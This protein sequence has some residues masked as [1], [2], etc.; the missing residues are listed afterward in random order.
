MKEKAKNLIIRLLKNQLVKGSTTLFLGG[1]IGNLANYLYHLLMG[2]MLG[3][4]D[5]GALESVISLLYIFGIPLA[6]VNL[7]VVRTVSGLRGRGQEKKAAS[8]YYSLRRKIFS[9]AVGG[10]ILLFAAAPFIKNFLHLSSAW[11]V[12]VM[13]SHSFLG[14]FTGLNMAFLGAF[15]KFLSVSLI[16]VFQALAKLASGVLLVSLG[17]SVLGGSMAFLIGAILG[18][19]ISNF[20]IRKLL[21]EG[22]YSESQVRLKKIIKDAAAPFILTISFTSLYTTDI[23]LA[24]HFLP[25]DQAGFYAALSVLGKIIFFAAGPVAAT[26][27]PLV[28]SRHAAGADYKKLFLLS[29]GLVFLIC[30]SV[31]LVYWAFPGLMVRMLFGPKYQASAQHL[32]IFGLFLSFYSLANLICQF[33]LSISRN[34]VVLFP[35]VAALFQVILILLFHQNLFEV[36]FVSMIVSGLLFFILM[37]YSLVTQNTSG[38]SADFTLEVKGT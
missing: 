12:L 8:F 18:L 11:P 6:A 29:L 26:M 22:N 15:L 20:I 36:A 13:I 37:V 27:F 24:R 2:R 1:I 30:L 34:K 17:W 31:N 33:F 14:V 21:K 23:V 5:Y 38:V 19:G 16:G 9:L 4:S 10:L 35:L 7:V 3:P 32:I 25:A 28:S